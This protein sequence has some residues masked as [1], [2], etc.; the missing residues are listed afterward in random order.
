MAFLSALKSHQS[1]TFSLL[2]WRKGNCK[3]LSPLTS[4]SCPLGESR[5]CPAARGSCS[6]RSLQYQSS[7]A[8][9]KTFQ[10]KQKV[11]PKVDRRVIKLYWE[12]YCDI[13]HETHLGRRYANSPIIY[14][15]S[16]SLAH[17]SLLDH[18]LTFGTLALGRTTGRCRLAGAADLLLQGRPLHT[19][20]L[21][22]GQ[23]HDPLAGQQVGGGAPGTKNMS[24]SSSSWS[25]WNRGQ[26]CWS[27]F[28]GLLI[29][30]VS[31]ARS[32]FWWRNLN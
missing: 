17:I 26:W 24:T 3:E 4:L 9:L 22:L 13:H 23:L 7:V 2:V 16:L 31:G 6:P 5:V 32:M 20:Q 27:D 28:N 11:F 1:Q 14:C 30:L 15:H 10:T 21:R 18:L 19:R 29:L 12:L 8:G 25:S